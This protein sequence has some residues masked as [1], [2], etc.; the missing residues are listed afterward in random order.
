MHSLWFPLTF[1][2]KLNSLFEMLLKDLHQEGVINKPNM[3]KNKNKKTNDTH[4]KQEQDRKIKEE[5]EK[6][7]LEAKL[8]LEKEERERE[9]RNRKQKS[10]GKKGGSQ[11]ETKNKESKKKAPST[12]YH[13]SD[14][15]KTVSYVRENW[16]IIVLLVGF[17]GIVT[18]TKMR[19]EMYSMYSMGA[20][21]QVT[22]VI[23]LL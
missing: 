17:F 13:V 4:A 11:K 10:K 20:G 15:K 18:F 19:E 2:I 23:I 12:G 21:Q 5:K 6:Q 9:A 16:K 8:A 3:G 22:E 14:A 1:E 7:E